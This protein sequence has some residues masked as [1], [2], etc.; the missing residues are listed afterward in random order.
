MMQVPFEFK[1]N[2]SQLSRPSIVEASVMSGRV[3][4]GEKARIKLKV[5]CVPEI[6]VYF[7][8]A[9]KHFGNARINY[10]MGHHWSIYE[11]AGLALQSQQCIL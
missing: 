9:Q 8:T 10:I 2:L 11:L 3:Q 1:V 4:A 6:N 5:N 7:L